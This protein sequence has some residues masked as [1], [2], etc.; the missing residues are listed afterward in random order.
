MKDKGYF[1]FKEEFRKDWYL[2]LL[3]AA[4]F[5]VSCLLYSRLPERMPIHWN[6]AVRLIITP[7]VS[8]GLL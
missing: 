2:L 5:L 6:I 1:D 7:A 3:I 8:G 4:M